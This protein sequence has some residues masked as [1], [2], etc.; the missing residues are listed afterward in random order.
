MSGVRASSM[1]IESTSSTIAK[2]W[3]RC[4]L[5]LERS[6]H[7]VA[8]VVEA[9]LV[10]RPVG[11]VRRVRL[12]LERRVVDVGEHHADLEPEEPVDAAHPLGVAL[13][14]VV[15]RGHLVDAETGDRVEVRREGRDQGLALTGLHLGDPAEVER[16]AAHQLHVEVALTERPPAGLADGGERLGEEVVEVLAPLEAA[17]ELV[18]LRAELLVGEALHVGLERV[19]LRDDRLQ[20]LEFPALARVE[21]PLEEAHCRPSYRWGRR[22]PAARPR[23]GPAAT[24]GGQDQS[25]GSRRGLRRG[26]MARLGPVD[27]LV[28]D[29][30]ELVGDLVEDAVERG[31]GVG[32]GGVGLHQVLG[33]VHGDLALLRVGDPWV[34]DLRELDLDPPDVGGE[35]LEL[36]QLLTAVGVDRRID[37][38]VATLHHDLDRHVRPSPSDA[39][40]PPR[41]P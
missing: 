36:R 35:A 6:A 38:N 26:G 12:A 3:P 10:V 11:D 34:L 31:A 13:G 1:R 20:E 23:P 40:A 2:L 5:F 15:V 30:G 37:G 7:V 18:G 39:L 17:P 16:G 41:F 19:D 27:A 32:G 21:D 28:V 29:P 25:T 8:Q 14:E 24:G 4:G 33:Q 22:N 9:E